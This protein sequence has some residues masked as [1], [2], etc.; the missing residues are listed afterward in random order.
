MY[1]H[2]KRFDEYN[3]CILFIEN[4]IIILIEK[5]KDFVYTKSKIIKHLH[6]VYN[7]FYKYISSKYEKNEII[8]NNFNIFKNDIN[9]LNIYRHEKIYREQELD[10]KI[11]ELEQFYNRICNLEALIYLY[12]I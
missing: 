12:T 2:I 3:N 9:T 6:F 10:I 5:N 4:T 8:I 7:S 1:E 11:I